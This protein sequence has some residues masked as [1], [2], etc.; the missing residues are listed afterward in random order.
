MLREDP[1]QC[2]DFFKRTIHL[3]VFSVRRSIKSAVGLFFVKKKKSG[4]IRMV[5]DCR[6]TNALHRRPPAVK[7]GS[8]GAFSDIDLSPLSPASGGSGELAELMIAA[9]DADFR[10]GFYQME[11]HRIASW[12][13]IEERFLAEDL[14]VTECWCDDQQRVRPLSA[15]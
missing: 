10:D 8:V 12:F 13:G 4:D 9:S 6:R 11:V 5:V 3:K 2:H 14:G 1:K 7:L 15:S